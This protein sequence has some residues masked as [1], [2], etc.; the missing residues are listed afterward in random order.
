MKSNCG[1]QRYHGFH[2]TLRNLRV[3]T[4][5]PV[6]GYG[7]H[8]YGYGVGKPDPRITRFKP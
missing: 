6:A 5:S 2:G 7:V 1:Y 3:V 8:R 4:V